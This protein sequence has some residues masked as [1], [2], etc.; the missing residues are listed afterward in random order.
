M[1][2]DDLPADLVL[3]PVL[4]PAD[5]LANVVADAGQWGIS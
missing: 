1:R 2:M 5:S 3:Q 4:E